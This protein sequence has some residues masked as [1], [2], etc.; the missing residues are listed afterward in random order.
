MKGNIYTTESV[1]ASI[2]PDE[3]VRQLCLSVF[4]ESVIEA[5]KFGAHKW[6]AYYTND[7][8][9]LLV[10]SLIVLTIEKHGIWVTLEKQLLEKSKEGRLVI[11]SSKDWQ[12]DTGRWS[13][14]KAVPSKNGF[15]IPS[16]DNLR[17][18]STIRR[19]HFSFID[20]AAKKYEQL[21]QDSQRKHMPDLLEYLG[22]ALNKSVPKP[23]YGDSVNLA[24]NPI[25]E[26]KE[27]QSTY[28]D[29]SETERESIIQSRIGQGRFRTELLSYWRSCAVT[30]C[31]AIE[32]LR[33]SHIKPW[34]VSNN[35]ERLDVYNG[36][37]LIPNLDASF[38]NGLIGFNDDGKIIISSLLTE[39]NRIM[40]GIRSDM[41]IKKIDKK[42]IVYLRYH[43]EH[44]FNKHMQ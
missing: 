36:L 43:R 32:V 12:W 24:P 11:E 15:Y 4:L 20:K 21:R 40:L 37:L 27:Y 10:G 14:Y 26:I 33:A 7:K 22:Y 30:G 44:V 9:R 31:E 28:Q 5:N 1:I 25:Q 29:L 18:W 34:R 35:E 16:K 23:F 38:D 2:I 13:E 39:D 19:L 6:G 41:R 3:E 42:H 17:I 8:I